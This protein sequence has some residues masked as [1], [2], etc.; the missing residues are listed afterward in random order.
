MT[1][2]YIKQRLNSLLAMAI[3]AS[4]FA[5]GIERSRA[6]DGTWTSTAG[7]NW[8]T[9]GDWS[10][11]VVA[12]GADGSANTAFFNTLDLT[13]DV[14]VTLDTARTNANMVFADT[15]TNTPANWILAGAGP[16]TLGG[17]TPTI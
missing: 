6:V 3:I 15:D 8:S 12:D 16:L 13:A 14:T 4:A 1:T 17:A 2:G 7:G 5:L 10:G 9:T 11:G